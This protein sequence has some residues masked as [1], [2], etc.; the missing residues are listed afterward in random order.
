MTL[1]FQRICFA[2]YMH[3]NIKDKQRSGGNLNEALTME[4]KWIPLMKE[5][6]HK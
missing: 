6:T 1:S 5:L 4:K 2:I 3:I